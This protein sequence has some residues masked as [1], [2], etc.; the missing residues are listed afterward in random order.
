MTIDR[1]V[2]RHAGS[3]QPNPSVDPLRRVFAVNILHH[4]S[5]SLLQE[6]QRWQQ[7]PESASYCSTVKG[8]GTTS[9]VQASY[10]A[11]TR[12]AAM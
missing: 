1:F 12:V 3:Q 8:A 7:E 4:L 11:W 2:W 5:G 6:P 9:V 10:E